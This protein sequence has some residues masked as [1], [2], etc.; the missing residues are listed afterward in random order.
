MTKSNMIPPAWHKDAKWIF[1]ILLV[2]LL[3]PTLLVAV[4]F[5]MTTEKNAVSMMSTSMA[6]AFSQKGIDDPTEINQF[7]NSMG[8]ASSVQPI[9]GL[10]I[11]ITKQDMENSSPREIRLNFFK[12]LAESFY[13]DGE[14]G[15]LKLATTE[16]MK[17]DMSGGVGFLSLFTANAHQF[18]QGLLIGASIVCLIFMAFFVY[19]S[20]GFGRLANPGIALVLVSAPGALLALIVKMVMEGGAIEP[21]VVGDF[22]SVA[23]YALVNFLPIILPILTGIYIWSLLAGFG[24]I[25]AAILGK[26]I[27]GLTKKAA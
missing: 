9:P 15:L 12:K 19:F 18:I 27:F 16:K 20:H 17:E 2:I 8:S 13:K 10:D 5:Q 14:Q 22:V 11:S 4:F 7:K 26:M 24:L 25:V 21:P 3:G 1:G 23:G 6:V